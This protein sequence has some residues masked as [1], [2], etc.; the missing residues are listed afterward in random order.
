M[1]TCVICDNISPNSS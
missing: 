1:T